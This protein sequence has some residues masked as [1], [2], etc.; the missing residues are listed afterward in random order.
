MQ[1]RISPPRQF[2]F[3][4]PN[5]G[6]YRIREEVLRRFLTK[7]LKQKLSEALDEGAGGAKLKFKGGCPNCEKNTTHEVALVSLTRRIN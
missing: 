2:F 7:K 4:C 1:E 5:C 6:V 3:E